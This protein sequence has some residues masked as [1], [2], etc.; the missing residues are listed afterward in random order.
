MENPSSIRAK[1]GYNLIKNAAHGASSSP[2]IGS[3]QGVAASPPHGAS[4]AASLL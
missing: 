3:H 2:W 4:A 1:F